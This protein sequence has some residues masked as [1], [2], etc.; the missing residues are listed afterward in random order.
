MASISGTIISGWC[1][2]TTRSKASPSSILNTSHSSATCMAGAPAYESQAM[3]YWP[4][5]WAEITNSLPSSPE[6]NNKIFFIFA[7]CLY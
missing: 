6:P 4:L 7:M 5:R 2:R 1:L 3:I